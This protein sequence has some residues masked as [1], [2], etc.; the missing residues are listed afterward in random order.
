MEDRM[1]YLALGALL[2]LAPAGSGDAQQIPTPAPRPQQQEDTPEAVVVVPVNPARVYQAACPALLDGRVTGRIVEPIVDG[3]CGILSPVAVEAVGARGAIAVTGKP[4]LNCG[5]ATALARIATAADEFARQRFGIGLESLETGSGYACRLRNRAAEG[6]I[7]EHAFANAIDITAFQLE[8]GQR[9]SVEASWPVV[10]QTEN[11]LEEELV[12]AIATPFERA[13]DDPA[14]FLA[15]VHGAACSIFSTV[16]GPDA[17][18]AHRS[19]FHFD[20]G[21]HGQDCTYLICE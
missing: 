14:R 20:L 7:S 16:L 12:E 8:D 1:K 3:A 11:G 5:M 17:N 10:R 2:A 6:K 21:C 19:H 13:D 15:D 18:A 4:V 9:V